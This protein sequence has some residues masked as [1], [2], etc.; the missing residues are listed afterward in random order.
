MQSI[1]SEQAQLGRVTPGQSGANVKDRIRQHCFQPKTSLPV[2]FEPFIV[3]ISF[4]S[5][6]RHSKDMLFDHMGPLGNVKGRQPYGLTGSH[7]PLG[8]RRVRVGKVQRYQKACIGV[9]AQ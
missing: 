9:R 8:V 2:L 5:R 1:E 7:K 6:K 3:A 4:D